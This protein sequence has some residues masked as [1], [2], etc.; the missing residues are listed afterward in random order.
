[1]LGTSIIEINK[2]AYLD[3][4]AFL[5]DYLQDVRI[6]SVM[7]ANAYGHG[8]EQMV[9][10]AEEA[11]I[12]YFA[13]FSGSEAERVHKIMHKNSHV[14]VMG[15]MSDERIEW[16]VKNGVEFFVFELEKLELAIQY[17]RKKKTKA[18][19]H[20]EIE[21]GMNRTGFTKVQL[22][23]VVQLLNEH[24]D[25]LNVKGLCTHYAGAESIANHV[26]VQKQIRNFNRLHKW[27]EEQGIHPEIKHTACSA[28]AV[29]YPKSRMDMVRIGILQYGFWPSR[30]TFIHYV[31]RRKEKTDPLRRVMTWKSQVMSLKKVKTGEFVS[32]GTSYLAQEPKRIAVV[33]VGYSHG[34]SRSLSNQG[35]VLIGGQRAP[36]IGAVNMNMMIADVTLIDQVEKGDEVVLI[37]NQNGFEITFASFADFNNQLNYELL[38]RLPIETP[39]RV[40][41]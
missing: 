17:A 25:F 4:L 7:K 12:D 8:I 15:W 16:A 32:Y 23:K 3:N 33:P 18:I 39:R 10:L 34:Y 38:A 24:A 30:E 28:A 13:V 9:P 20:L 19:I 6:C 27:I 22:K 40:V 36:V 1:M 5:K 35:R 31:H 37:G 11:G 41:S 26:R 29:A 21:T 2:Q 14:M